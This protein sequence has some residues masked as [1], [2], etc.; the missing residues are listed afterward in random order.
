MKWKKVHD[1]LSEKA[2]V[3]SEHLVKQLFTTGLRT[4]NDEYKLKADMII[5]I[6]LIRQLHEEKT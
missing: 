1:M 5:R 6:F 3:S 2:K 4:S